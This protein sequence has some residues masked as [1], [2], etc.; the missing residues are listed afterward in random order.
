MASSSHLAQEFIL[1]R[2]WGGCW[3]VWGR[4]LVGVGEDSKLNRYLS[5]GPHNLPVKVSTLACNFSP[6]SK[7]IEKMTLVR[8]HMQTKAP[9]PSNSLKERRKQTGEGVISR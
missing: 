6:T 8:Q 7:R 9:G 2:A 5:G 3:W 4:M 1:T